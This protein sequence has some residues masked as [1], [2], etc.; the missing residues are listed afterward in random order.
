MCKVCDTP[1]RC[2]AAGDCRREQLQRARQI[3]LLRASQNIVPFP[4]R[5]HNAQTDR[6]GDT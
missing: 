3:R 2:E 1:R 5:P 4:Q 6:K